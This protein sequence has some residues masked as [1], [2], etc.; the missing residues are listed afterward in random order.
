MKASRQ[1]QHRTAIIYFGPTKQDY[2]KLVKAESHRPYLD[3]AQ[4]FLKEQLLLEMHDD[5][6]NDSSCYT[7]HSQ[8][9]RS[10][11]GWLG[12]KEEIPICRVRCR[13]CR[14]VFTVLP[15][16][17]MRYRRQNTDCLGKLL[18][19]NLGM[20]LTQRE[21]ATI[22]SWLSED[23]GWHPGWI[24]NLVQ[25]LGNLLPVSLVLMSL[26]LSPPSIYSAMKSSLC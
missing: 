9:M 13:C 1:Y 7:I 4:P 18:E 10:L 2:L 17:I 25:W 5:G 6:C 15:S 26:G 24:W 19:M 11:Q 3:Y 8:R 16:F 14:A 12:E 22:Y 21:T 23:R 20:G